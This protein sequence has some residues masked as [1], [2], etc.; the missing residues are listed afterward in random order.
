MEAMNLT[1]M[2]I[3][4]G[5][6]GIIAAY[7]IWKDINATKTAK[8]MYGDAIELFSEALNRIN[9]T[10]Q[11]VKEVVVIVKEKVM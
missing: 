2:L 11:E 9:D 8:E 7:F 5:P 6:L 3:T 1:E 10:L 4:Y